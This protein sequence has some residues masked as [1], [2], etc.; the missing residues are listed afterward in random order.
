MS[1]SQSKIFLV[2]AHGAT[3][4]LNESHYKTEADLQTLLADNPDLLP[5]EQMSGSPQSW[6]LI[7]KE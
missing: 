1:S 4:V 3:T 5:G 6:L 2:D 7:G